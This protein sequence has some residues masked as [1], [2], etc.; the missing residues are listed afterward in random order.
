VVR[1]SHLVYLEWFLASTP[2]TV[3]KWIPDQRLRG[4]LAEDLER[5]WRQ[6]AEDHDWL[7]GYARTCAV[8]RARAEDYALREIEIS[9][10]TAVLAGI[11]FRNRNV[12]EPFVG[13]FAQTRDLNDGEI[14]AAT[15][16]LIKD[17]ALFR[18]LA[19]RWWSPEQ[20]DLR[21]LPNAAGDLRL[22]A[23]RVA[24]MTHLPGSLAAHLS[25]HPESVVD[26]YEEFRR[27]YAEFLA[28]ATF[29]NAPLPETPS[30]LEACERE[31]HLYCLRDSGRFAG[32]MA[33]RPDAIRGIKG[34]V[35][36]EEI[37]GAEYRGRGLAVAMQRIFV[38]TFDV[39]RGA[40]VMGEIADANL[41]SLR[42]ARG[43]GR[44]D[45]GG[46]VFI[47]A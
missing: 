9:P 14:A 13:V 21:G 23:G 1:P 3:R 4:D 43:A 38:S 42:T 25:F 2:D 17:F 37:L 36:F 5:T 11:H 6:R 18:P 44:S 19:V 39:A 32:L 46:W 34:W 27:A 15:R 7:A 29:H 12:S 8:E 28:Q 22:V 20:R 16:V 41:P 35:I 24:D 31:G 33:A 10:G 40:L 45:I 26:C 30:S 47:G